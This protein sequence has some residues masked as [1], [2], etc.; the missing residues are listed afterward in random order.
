MFDSEFDFAQ[1]YDMVLKVSEHSNKISHVSKCLYYQRNFKS[2]KK[3][4]SPDEKI[5]ML[6]NHFLRQ[7]V[8][9]TVSPQKNDCFKIDYA[10][11]GN[12]LVS[13]LIPTCDH[14]QMLKKC[15]D[16]LEKST[17]ENYEIILI[18]NNSKESET[19]AFYDSLK[20]NPKIKQLYWKGEFNFSAINNFAV[21]HANGEYIV[22]LNNDTEVISPNWIE[23]M[24]MFAQRKDVGAVG[25]KL[26]FPNGKIQHGGDI[27]AN[28]PN[29]TFFKFPV[30]SNG[31]ENR[32]T[33]VQNYSMVTAACMMISRK[34]YD[35]M[36]GL[37]ENFAVGYN[38]VDMCLRIRKAGY[39][40]VWTP[41]AELYH[42]ESESRGGHDN[43]ECKIR[44][45]AENF[46][47]KNYHGDK[48]VDPFYNPNLNQWATDFSVTGDIFPE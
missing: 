23:E 6:E 30:D 14:W 26:Y 36:S 7:N 13:I 15:I 38:D 39:Q 21:S 27:Y 3:N 44:A 11:S 28:E 17:W 2:D 19:F 1:D 46:L 4:A 41:Y 22:L 16:S 42:K 29:H 34:V 10:I 40:I 9:A 33:V 48:F 5:R 35:S 37:N 45:K 18:E 32:L 20:S 43:I 12:P 47:L 31:Y 25:A 24:L 8:S